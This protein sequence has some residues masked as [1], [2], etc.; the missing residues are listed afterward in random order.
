MTQRWVW[1]AV[2]VWCGVSLF[3][4]AYARHAWIEAPEVAAHCDAGAPG[5]VC[6]LRA[7]VI[8]AFIHQRL[9]WTALGLAALAY[10][11]AATWMAAIA[12]FLACSGL[13]LYSTEL[14][15]PAALLAALVFAKVGHAAAPAKQHSNA[16]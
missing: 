15:A 13:V 11:L 1:L 14:C 5:I 4:A 12:L 10:G 2:A 16:P 3:M 9:G 6:T 7:W 8:Q